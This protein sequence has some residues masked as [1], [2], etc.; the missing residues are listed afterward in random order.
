[1]DYMFKNCKSL[2]NINISQKFKISGGTKIVGIFNQCSIL[3][4]N[5]IKEI[6]NDINFD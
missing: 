2:K 4:K 3:L 6:N 5:K 1:M